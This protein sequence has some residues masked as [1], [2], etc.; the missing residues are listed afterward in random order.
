MD[1]KIRVTLLILFLTQAFLGISGQGCDISGYTADSCASRYVFN[2]STT[3]G[4]SFN[5]GRNSVTFL[6]LLDLNRTI[7]T[8]DHQS[9]D[10]DP[11]IIAISIKYFGK[12]RMNIQT[13]ISL[14]G[15][16]SKRFVIQTMKF[17][18]T[19]SIQNG[20]IF[21]KLNHNDPSKTGCIVEDIG[22]MSIT[23]LCSN[24][25]LT[26]TISIFV[27]VVGGTPQIS[28][29]YIYSK[30]SQ[31]AKLIGNDTFTIERIGVSF[32]DISSNSYTLL[33]DLVGSLSI[34]SNPADFYSLITIDALKQYGVIGKDKTASISSIINE[35]PTPSPSQTTVSV[36]SQQTYSLILLIFLIILQTLLH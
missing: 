10:V 13:S 34:H 12:C 3:I 20:S 5:L 29:E 16:E 26:K 27:N 17:T 28:N 23:G 9:G 7:I 30:R 15:L 2:N 32:Q 19:V 14:D 31:I 6:G 35:P 18:G 1:I 25:P 22:T 21:Y 24:G 4:D 11:R 33:I 36:S 8:F